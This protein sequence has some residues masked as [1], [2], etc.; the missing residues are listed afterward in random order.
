MFLRILLAIDG[1]ESGERA[2]RVVAG[3]AKTSGAEVIVFHGRERELIAGGHSAAIFDLESREDAS[4]I[5]DAA[6]RTLKDSGLSARGVFAG[7][8][9]GRLP[10]AIVDTAKTED[11]GLIVMGTRGL[12]DW[13]ALFLGSSTHRVLQLSDVP[14]MVIP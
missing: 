14:V 9:H 1:S 12:S 5:V 6:V 2:T 13:G 4:E 7:V 8:V 10:R 3:L 11:A